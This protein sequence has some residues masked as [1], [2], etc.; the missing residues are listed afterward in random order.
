MSDYFE[1]R[2][3]DASMYEN[4]PLAAYFKEV[5]ESIDSDARI[6]DF[7]CGFGQNLCALKDKNFN[8]EMPMGGGAANK[9][10]LI[11]NRY[12]QAC[13]TACAKSWDRCDS[14]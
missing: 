11:W 5:L 3:V 8:F 9:L 13:H 12:Q 7:G 10:S 14:L 2:N 4:T 6:L 1:A